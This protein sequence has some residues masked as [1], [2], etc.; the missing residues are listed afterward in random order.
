MAD[1]TLRIALWQTAGDPGNDAAANLD[2]L[3]AA[4]AGAAAAGAGLLVAPEMF[5]SGYAI[6]REA[7]ARGAEP[8]EGPAFRRAAQIA[9]RHGIAL[10]YGYPERGGDGAVYNAAVLVGADGTLLLN[11]RKTHLFAELDRSM[12]AP[13]QEIGRL[14]QLGAFRV[15]LL[16][17]YDVEH[18][19]AVRSLALAGADLVIVP[20]AN[21]KPHERVSHLVVPARAFENSVYVAYANRV[22][23]EG[24]LDY[25]GLSCVG[26]PSGVNVALAGEGEEMIVAEL[27]RGALEA[28][29][30]FNT[31]LAD[32]RPDL[33]GPLAN[34]ASARHTTAA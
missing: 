6:G 20:T 30:R 31:Y 21:M 19:E 32:R 24:A 15:G 12:F 22:G 11:Y 3:E 8:A 1:E 2:R 5:L 33:Y 17:C 25:L 23:R 7:A 28:A 34:A 27:S 29:R 18:P 10:A 14:A 16:I 9:R 4:A 26:G 13:G